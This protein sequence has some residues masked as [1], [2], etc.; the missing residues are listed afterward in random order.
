MVGYNMVSSILV[1]FTMVGFTMVDSTM[2]GFTMVGSTMVSSTIDGIFFKSVGLP[3]VY[4]IFNC[5]SL[6]LF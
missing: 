4:L 3:N 5:F 2:V 1:G 6:K